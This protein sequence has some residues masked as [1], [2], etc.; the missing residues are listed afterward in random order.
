MSY[1]LATRLVEQEVDCDAAALAALETE[2]E[3]KATE[4]MGRS[5]SGGGF[6]AQE[7]EGIG[8]SV[9]FKHRR[10]VRVGAEVDYEED[11]EGEGASRR[12][13]ER[14][15]KGEVRSWCGWCQRVIPSK[16]DG[17][18]NEWNLGGC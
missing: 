6:A 2:A 17:W 4:G 15:M 8:G 14:E 1:C 9:K 5:W 18:D 12:Y 16:E 11:E 13:L 7:M 3:R 10:L